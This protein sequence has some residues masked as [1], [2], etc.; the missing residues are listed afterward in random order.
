VLD[1]TEIV[2]ASHRLSATNPVTAMV[3]QIA[4]L[5]PPPTS[6]NDAFRR[7][8]GTR[9]VVLAAYKKF[10]EGRTAGGTGGTGSIEPY[11][12]YDRYRTGTEP[13]YHQPHRSPR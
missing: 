5:D 7:I 2:G 12:Q 11:R 4:S 1:L 10:A 3:D 9:S 13:P 8:R 6:G